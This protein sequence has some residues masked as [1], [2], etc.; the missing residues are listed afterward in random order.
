MGESDKWARNIIG[1][2]VCLSEY[3]IDS[4]CGN[5]CVIVREVDT[6]LFSE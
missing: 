6:E 5:E 3:V 4:I 1:V 2:S